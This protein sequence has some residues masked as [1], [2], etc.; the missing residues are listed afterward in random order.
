[1]MLLTKKA[2][3]EP[4]T[5][6][7]IERKIKEITVFERELKERYDIN[8]S[9]LLLYSEEV[10]DISI[11]R[12]VVRESDI[13]RTLAPNL[14]LV[15]YR[16]VNDQ[17]AMK[18][19]ENLLCAYQGIHPPQKMYVALSSQDEELSLMGMEHRLIQL[20]CYAIN[21]NRWNHIFTLYD[22]L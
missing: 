5:I 11:C 19:T 17:G 13:I 18:A 8:Y 7:R 16:V 15:I 3:N 20:L 2:I 12:G 4:I 21:E 6:Q 14:L 1:M 9:G 10:I 22:M